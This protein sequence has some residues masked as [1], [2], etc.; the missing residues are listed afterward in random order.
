MQYTPR[1]RSNAVDYSNI[2]NIS[3]VS[4]TNH[5]ID[6]TQCIYRH[7]WFKQLITK[8]FHKNDP[9]ILLFTS[10]QHYKN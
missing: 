1:E 4:N 3:N 5:T 2:S 9:D 7:S 8:I 10:L 6:F